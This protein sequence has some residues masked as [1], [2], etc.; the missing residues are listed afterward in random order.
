METT[1]STPG[2]SGDSDR[3][4]RRQRR[5]SPSGVETARAKTPGDARHRV[6]TYVLRETISQLR[7]NDVIKRY[8]VSRAAEW[9]VSGG[10]G[11]MHFWP[12]DAL[13]AAIYGGEGVRPFNRRRRD[14]ERKKLNC[15]RSPPVLESGD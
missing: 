15:S 9:T 11:W 4:R 12:R 13:R 5:R 10:S 1:T 7:L 8:Y 14:N 6:S 3:C 2:V